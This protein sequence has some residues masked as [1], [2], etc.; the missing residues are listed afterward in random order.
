VFLPALRTN[1]RGR[2][3]EQLPDLPQLARDAQRIDPRS[4]LVR[5]DEAVHERIEARE[6]FFHGRR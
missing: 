4:G 3:G 1:D 6:G 2:F 5:L